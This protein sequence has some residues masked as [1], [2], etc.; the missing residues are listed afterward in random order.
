MLEL[1]VVLV[2]L[3]LLAAVATPQVMNYLDSAKVDAARLQIKNLG[4]NLELFRLDVGR[5]PTQDEGL[6]ALVTRPPNV[7]NW[8]GPFVQRKESL[9]D[10]WGAPYKYR[11]PGQHGQYDLWSNGPAGGSGRSGGAPSV[12]NW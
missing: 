1:L 5:Y 7:E 4:T 3:G 11:M 9:I 2:I 10:P 6:E 12:A 8:R